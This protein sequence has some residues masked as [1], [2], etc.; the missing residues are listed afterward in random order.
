M[1]DLPVTNIIIIVLYCI[2]LYCIVLYCIV[3]HCMYS[4]D[5]KYS[6]R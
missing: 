3:L 4:G 2:V 1:V 6:R 5:D